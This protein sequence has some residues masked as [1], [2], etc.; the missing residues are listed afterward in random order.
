L[1]NSLTYLKAGPNRDL[2]QQQIAQ[3]EKAMP[4]SGKK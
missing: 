2:V 4:P 1:Q 3:L